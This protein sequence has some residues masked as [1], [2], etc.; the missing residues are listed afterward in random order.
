[1][2][3]HADGPTPALFAS[4]TVALTEEEERAVALAAH[5]FAGVVPVGRSADLAKEWT[6]ARGLRAWEQRVEALCKLEGAEV[7]RHGVIRA[8][9]DVTLVADD[10]ALVAAIVGEVAAAKDA[11]MPSTALLQPLQPASIPRALAV[12]T[13]AASASIAAVVRGCIIQSAARRDSVDRL[14]ARAAE[15]EGLPPYLRSCRVRGPAAPLEPTDGSAHAVAADMDCQRVLGQLAL[16][17]TA[18]ELPA[19]KY[20][21]PEH[22]AADV[23][24]ELGEMAARHWEWSVAVVR[25]AEALGWLGGCLKLGAHPPQPLVTLAVSDLADARARSLVSTQCAAVAASSKPGAST[26]RT[27]WGFLCCSWKSAPSSTNHPSLLQTRSVEF[28]AAAMQ[29]R[30]V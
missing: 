16:V 24:R 4:C 17:P 23:A 5:A 14:L 26:V 9:K 29:L 13:D 3:A 12:F 22:R 30:L 21:V 18:A 1:M 28:V 19:G 11:A 7:R 8:L 20:M 25:P 15:R 2:Q 10:S 27:C 6:T